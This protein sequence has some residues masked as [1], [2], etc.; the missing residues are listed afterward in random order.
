MKARFD[1]V[2]FK[3]SKLVTKSYSTSFSLGVR[4]LDKDIRGAIYSIY[5]FV[6]FADEIVDSFHDHNKEYLLDKFEKDYYDAYTHNISLNPILNSFQQTVKKYNIQ[7]ELIQSFLKSMRFDLNKKDYNEDEFK[8]YIYGS[9]EA[10]GLM[11]LKVF[12]KGCNEE[13]EELLKHA[14]SLGAAFQ[15]VN[16]LRDIQNDTETLNRVY[17]PM[18]KEDQFDAETKKEIFNDIQNDFN[19]ALIGIKRL[20]RKAKTGVYTAYTY[21]LNLNKKLNNKAPEELMQ[22]RIR[23]SNFKKVL[24]LMR[25]FIV[26]NLKMV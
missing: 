1:H 4:M 11:C 5:G 3:S 8:E 10:V 16:F 15:K 18:I 20:P 19:D 24:L 26:V 9:A 25:A 13:Y 7:D 14:K 23:I 17:F 12:L 6:R 21:Y 2:S 22:N